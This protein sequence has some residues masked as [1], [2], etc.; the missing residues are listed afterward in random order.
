MLDGTTRLL[1]P[2]SKCGADRTEA[3]DDVQAVADAADEERVQVLV[4]VRDICNIELR[5][6]LQQHSTER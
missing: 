5:M 6:E 1:C 4:R 2:S 3:E